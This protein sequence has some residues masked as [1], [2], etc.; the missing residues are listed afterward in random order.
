[1]MEIVYDDLYR[2]LLTFFE[3]G[4]CAEGLE[5]FSKL[6]LLIKERQ[7]AAKGIKE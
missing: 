4:K 3:V 1:M 7:E 5:R 2:A 6:R